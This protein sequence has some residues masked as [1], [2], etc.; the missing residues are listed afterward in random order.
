MIVTISMTS[1]ALTDAGLSYNCIESKGELDRLIRL[2][3]AKYT[4]SIFFAWNRLIANLSL[5]K[6]YHDTQ[7]GHGL[8]VTGG[9][10][11]F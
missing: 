2:Y 3:P 8:L 7:N 1:L 10:V 11:Y 6:S 5:L 9:Y 4:D